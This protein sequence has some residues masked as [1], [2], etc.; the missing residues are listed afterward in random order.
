MTNLEVKKTYKVNHSRKGT[1]ELKITSLSEEW[2]TGIIVN[3]MARA[4]LPYNEKEIGEEI[5]IRRSF[6]RFEEIKAV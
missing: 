1:F 4:M 3:G 5:T 6:C 2:V